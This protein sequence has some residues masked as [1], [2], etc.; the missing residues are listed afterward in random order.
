MF[1][2]DG[3]RSLFTGLTNAF[4]LGSQRDKGSALAF[5]YRTIDPGELDAMYRGD[6]LARKIVDIIP[7]DM[8]RE[9]RDW[10]A[11]KDVI[12]AIER[13][14]K[15]PAVDLPRKVNRALRRARL[16]GGSAVFIG[17]R[18]AN[19]A[20]E[21][22]LDRIGRDSI[23][24]LHVLGRDELSVGLPISDVTN[25]LFGE[26]EWYEVR[27]RNGN[28][29][30]IHPSRMVRFVGMEVLTDIVRADDVWGDSVLQVVYD[31]IRNATSAQS[32]I[33]ALIPE[34]KTDVIYVPGLS[35][36]VATK[37]GEEALTKR[38]AY[39]AQ[40]KSMFSMLLLEGNGGSGDTAEG[41]RWEQKQISFAQ[42]PELMRQYLQIAAG[43]ADIPAIRL[44]GEAP[45]GL[46]SNGES[47]LVTYYD[48]IGARQRV[49][50][51]P[52][53][54]RLD[55]V[56]IRSATG[57]RDPGIYY[58]WAPLWS[59]SEKEKADVFDK[60]AGA[61][62]KLA[63]SGQEK[64]LL[65]I[66]PLSIALAN[67]LVEDGVLPGLDAA[68]DAYDGSLDGETD[69]ANKTA[70][71]TPSAEIIPLRVAANDAEPRPLYVHRKIRNG[72]AILR[73]AKSQG[74]TSTLDAS[75]LHVT[76]A[77]SRKPLDWMAVPET[78]E[79]EIKLAAGGP[80]L[81][82]QFGEATVLLFASMSLKWRHEE[83]ERAGASWDHPEYQPHITISYGGA[84]ADLSKVQPYQG[85]IVLGPEVFEPIDEDWK[86]RVTGKD[87]A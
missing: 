33:A 77:Y 30:R 42:M 28:V 61:A 2:T 80:R 67:R 40:A 39:A 45:S 32:H 70:A 73:W 50:L 27:S 60:V 19:H 16:K 6:W 5:G 64:P 26:P 38:F 44:L 58:E 12:E 72:D 54:H 87:D 18:G 4:G 11:A 83:I 35:E 29:A 10:Q 53:L 84:P 52:Q 74:F 69:E 51:A 37:P 68:I 75:D 1:T 81:M 7:N 21:L 25:P 66:D 65:P 62:R 17:I 47:S 57:S 9:W 8:T 13:V 41:E 63:G 86:A 43:A 22:L 59:L 15:L 24:Y 49:D 36:A 46:G 56:I 55:E 79:S 85:E 71:L 76:I 78:W 20:D 14:E 34:L 48:N 82:D 31:A 3:L 23:E